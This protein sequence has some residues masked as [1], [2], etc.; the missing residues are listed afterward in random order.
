MRDPVEWR[1]ASVGEAGR[2][3]PNSILTVRA[4]EPGRHKLFGWRE[5]TNEV[6]KALDAR[7]EH[8]VFVFWEVTR[9]RTRSS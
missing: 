4:S 3:S 1:F 8:V 7:E 9:V 6:I 2:P 5:L